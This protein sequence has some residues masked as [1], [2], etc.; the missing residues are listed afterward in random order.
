MIRRKVEWKQ[1]VSRPL[2]DESNMEGRNVGDERLKRVWW[3][4]R[5][6]QRVEGLTS[7]AANG[8]GAVCQT[9]EERVWKSPVVTDF[10]HLKTKT[11][12]A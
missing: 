7:R 2:C 6:D 10:E 4:R 12:K 3:R 5:A 8:Q 9:G 11:T 1:R